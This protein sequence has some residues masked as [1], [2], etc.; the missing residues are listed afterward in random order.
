LPLLEKRSADAVLI[1]TAPA[2][3][4]SF[5]KSLKRSQASIPQS[6]LP[7]EEQTNPI[8]SPSPFLNT[9]YQPRKPGKS[10]FMTS[11]VWN[12][13]VKTEEKDGEGRQKLICKLCQQ[14]ALPEDKCAIYRK[15]S[16]TTNLKNHLIRHH[17]IDVDKASDSSESEVQTKIP[18][19]E[20]EKKIAAVNAPLGGKNRMEKFRNALMWMLIDNTLPFRLVES[21]SFQALFRLIAPDLTIPSRKTITEETDRLYTKV[22]QRISEEIRHFALSVTCDSAVLPTADRDRFTT[23]T[24]HFVDWDWKLRE[25]VI[26][27][28]LANT[29]Q[30]AEYVSDLIDEIAAEYTATSRIF[31]ACSDNGS[32]YVKGLKS[33]RSIS[34][35]L[36]CISHSLQ[37]CV[38]NGIREDNTLNQLIVKAR[39]LVARVKKSSVL[40]SALAEEQTKQSTA[41]D[42]DDISFDPDA[43]EISEAPVQPAVYDFAQDDETDDMKISS[44]MVAQEQT[45]KV[46]RTYSLV[47]DVQT[48]F[49]STYYLA[50]RLVMLKK[51]LTAVLLKNAKE[52]SQDEILTAAEFTALEALVPILALVR[53]A[54]DAMEA[55][56]FPTI[57]LLVPVV[58][59]MFRLL[60]GKVSKPIPI[61]RWIFNYAELVK[62]SPAKSLMARVVNELK[63]RWIHGYNSDYLPHA[64]VLLDPRTRAHLHVLSPEV[65]EVC[66]LGLESFLSTFDPKEFFS[67]E[68]LAAY[69]LYVSNGAQ[70]L[71]AARDL[72]R[73]LGSASATRPNLSSPSSS[74]TLNEP[75]KRLR[76]TSS[77]TSVGRMFSAMDAPVVEQK[78]ELDKFL[79][80]KIGVELNS[81]PFEWWSHYCH[82]FPTIGLAALCQLPIPVTQASSERVF[83]LSNEILR[84]RRRRLDS[85]RMARLAILKKNIL[86]YQDLTKS[87]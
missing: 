82:E 34:Y 78:S 5:Q 1:S 86:L 77:Q 24:A 30:C 72:V 49:N 69:K 83:S 29:S 44:R 65:L 46:S 25:A 2:N 63:I 70:S 39:K 21:E 64:G 84:P 33:N 87:Q 50:S 79:E 76:S 26:S 53:T 32:N 22:H 35:N 20:G 74:S 85:N 56:T 58:H 3:P 62:Y 80:L 66:K 19:I 10:G 4:A 6:T 59:F 40:T 57:S 68:F 18:L 37:L 81:D 23:A 13:I 8:S 31:S 12:Y 38:K 28:E 43:L 61:D 52:F 36:R 73:N 60:E 45:L 54:S 47:T 7:S 15:D 11:A 14:Q 51:P 17:S 16:S 42:M 9:N 71:R 75:Q 67:T 41:V 55:S 27:L 48:R